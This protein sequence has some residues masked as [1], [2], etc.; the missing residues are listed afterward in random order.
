MIMA[1][2]KFFLK[3]PK[4]K[5][6]TLIYLF[7]SY[8]NKRLKY[9]TGE[10][11]NPT[12]WNKE[13]RLARETTKFPEYPEFNARLKKIKSDVLDIHRELLNDETVPT[14]ELLKKELDKR[15]KLKGL[16]KKDDIFSFIDRYIEESK[17]IKAPGTIRVYN[18]AKAHLE[19]YCKEYNKQLD[20]D[21]I[22]L[23]FYNSFIS[24]LT[25]ENYSQNTIG[26]Q[27]KVLKTFL[28]EA[29]DRGINTTLDF[30]KRKF[31][32]P[33]EDNDKIYLNTEE[34]ERLYNLKIEKDKQLDEI[35][36]L[37][38][39]GCY[40]GLRFSD[41]TQLKPENIVDGNKIRIRTNKTNELVIIPLHK[42][43]RE[44]LKKYKNEIPQALSNSKMNLSLKHLGR[45]AKITENVESSITKGG[46]LVKTTDFKYNLITTHTARRSF[47]TNLY[48][49]DIPGITIMKITGHQT[50]KSFLRYI[51]ISQE[52]NAN[53]LL[54]HEFFK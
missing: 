34:L 15:A 47:A 49:A 50:E 44:I 17:I 12:F 11:I 39:I 42:Y 18:R 38:I 31:K 32:R 51:R 13:K 33:T 30:K 45:I 7:F 14:N 43:V 25:K 29:T 16:E 1:V 4:S 54:N 40:T 52:E 5:D 10:K 53:K 22:N 41:F 19:N 3:E 36:D 21:N 20:F 26:K 24:Y 8:N 6:E 46:K 9:S 35:R 2:A 27:I 37:F 23:E 48:L 28:N